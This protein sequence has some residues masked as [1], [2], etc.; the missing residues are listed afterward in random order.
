MMPTICTLHHHALTI[1]IALVCARHM[2]H[3]NEG[4][5]NTFPHTQSV[6]E[7]NEL[8]GNNSSS[9]G[10]GYSWPQLR[11][12]TTGKY[13]FVIL[14]FRFSKWLVSFGFAAFVGKC[15]C[16][17]LYFPSSHVALLAQR[18]RGA[19]FAQQKQKTFIKQRAQAQP[20]SLTFLM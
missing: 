3:A 9:E 12:N 11:P 13:S 6:V 14:P 10:A 18:E 7:G 16:V 19:T 8:E 20:D 5:K 17:N 1:G 4:L 15:S 2:V